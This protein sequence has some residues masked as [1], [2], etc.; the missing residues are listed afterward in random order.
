MNSIY[1]WMVS[2]RFGHICSYNFISFNIRFFFSVDIFYMKTCSFREAEPRSILEGLFCGKD[3]PKAPYELT[4]CNNLFCP[5]CHPRNHWRKSQSW[6][7][8]DFQSSSMH[9]FVNGYTTY[10]NCPAVCYFS[11]KYLIIIAR[12]ITLKFRHVIHRI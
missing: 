1:K 8:V 7:V 6:S 12:T 9:Q 5:C 10:L 4:P 2:S 11:S 3:E